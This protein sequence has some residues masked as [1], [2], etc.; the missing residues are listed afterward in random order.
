MAEPYEDLVNPALLKWA[1]LAAPLGETQ[2][3]TPICVVLGEADEIA[4]MLTDYWETK[5]DE[6]GNQIPGFSGL[7]TTNGITLEVADEIRDIKF[8]VATTHS[9][10]L[11]LIQSSA[12][13]SLDR[14][15]L[16][17]SEIRLT[18]EFL[19]DAKQQ[20]PNAELEN[21][22][23]AFAGAA[24]QAAIALALE[25]YA[26]FASR[27]RG[28]LYEIE[29]FNVALIDEA[30]TLADALREQSAI[31]LRRTSADE[32]R[33]VLALRN[34]LLTLMLDRVTHVCRA[35]RYLFRNHHDLARKFTS[36]HERKQR[37]A[38]TTAPRSTTSAQPSPGRSHKASRTSASRITPS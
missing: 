27:N 37:P 32:Q 14:A 26:G 22:H 13:A 21:L 9:V 6:K 19:F 30:R 12:A 34:R 17:L 28:M 10:Y 20:E 33:Q 3:D 23:G 38:T 11:A 16:V 35:A 8:A 36:L 1:P 25:G 4:T 2:L 18:L 15:E 7:S 29:G 24:S 31:A 5:K